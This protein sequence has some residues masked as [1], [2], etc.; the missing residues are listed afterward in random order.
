MKTV[1][2]EEMNWKDIKEA[3]NQGYTTVIIG[4]G[5]IEQL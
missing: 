5:S 3:M 2:I 4:I 1:R